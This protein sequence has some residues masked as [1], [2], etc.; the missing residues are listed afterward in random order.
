MNGKESAIHAKFSDICG[1]YLKLK[2]KGCYLKP[3]LKLV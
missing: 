2:L 3:M 1:D